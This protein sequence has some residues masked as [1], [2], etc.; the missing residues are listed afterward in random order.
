[1]LHSHIN[2]QVQY[3]ITLNTDSLLHSD[4]GFNMREL[5]N[6]PQITAEDVLDKI[7]E[8]CLSGEK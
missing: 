8:F 4:L 6:D 5:N 7:S 3:I 2:T 1:M